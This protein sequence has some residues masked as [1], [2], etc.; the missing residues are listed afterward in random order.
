MIDLGDPVVLT[1]L[2]KDASGALVDAGA[3]VCT[4]T[5][6]DNSTN[7]PTVSH[8]GTGTYAATFTT[9]QAGRHQVRWVA[10]G[11]NAQTYADV[12]NV[13]AASLPWIVGLAEARA[14]LGLPAG[15]TA[16]DEVL[17][18]KL[19]AATPVMED[20]VGPVLPAT[21]DDWLDGGATTVRV[22]NYPLISVTSVQESYGNF[23]RTLTAQPLDGPG[24][25][26]YGYTV[27]LAAGILQRR[28]SGRVGE[29]AAGRRNVHVTYQA[30]RTVT[31]A[32]I[33]EATLRLVRHLYQEEQQ[34]FARPEFGSGEPMVMTPSGFVVPR[35]V[36]ELCGNDSQIVG[37]A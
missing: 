2:V 4:V 6:P 27:D 19:T 16:N 30:G 33:I 5:L 7:T 13:T 18:S 3:A 23:T 17:R 14:S 8:T 25:D 24:F 9:T 11:A 20:I 32:N 1:F 10:T 34:G 22:L 28:T 26:A 31:P 36:I 21:F 12:F 29:F 35:A 37:I 15:A